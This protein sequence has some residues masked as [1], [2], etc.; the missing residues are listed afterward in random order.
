MSKFPVQADVFKLRQRALHVLEEAQRVL[1]FREILSHSDKLDQQRL[2]QLGD[3]MN[4]TQESCR[5]VYECSC[6]EIDDICNIA[7]RAGAYG[8][9][10]TGAGWGGCTVHLVP[11]DKEQAVTNALKK[12]YYSEKFPDMSQ[13]MLNDAIVISKPSQ[14]SSVIW[15]KALETV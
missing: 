2:Q 8:S 10:L 3:L 7:R 1:I 9:R 14:G 6:P 11:Q 5:D 4:K 12:E 15:G 13:E